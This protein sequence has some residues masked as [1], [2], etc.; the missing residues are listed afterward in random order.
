VGNHQ[1]LAESAPPG[2]ARARTRHA[3]DAQRARVAVVDDD[4]SIRFLV[5]TLLAR[6]GI[7]SIAFSSAEALLSG[8]Q[9]DFAGCLLLDLQLPG[10]NGLELQDELIR[11]GNAI[12]IIFFTAQGSIA[13]AVQALQHGAVDFIEKPFDHRVLLQKIQGAIERRA[14]LSAHGGCESAVGRLSLLT[15]REREV[16]EGVVA[17]RLNKRIADDLGI[18]VK[19]VEFHRAHI[20][21]KT[22]VHSVAELVRLTVLSRGTPAP[23]GGYV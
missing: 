13:K 3:T 4:E 10:R 16:M 1:V 19:T 8:Y 21:Q 12:P 11:R 5:Q 7:D 17:G 22:G 9:P 14:E 20:M 23:E 15:A 6:E 2:P 18:C